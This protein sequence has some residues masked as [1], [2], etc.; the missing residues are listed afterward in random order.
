MNRAAT[1]DKPDQFVLLLLLVHLLAGWAVVSIYDGVRYLL[2]GTIIVIAG[3]VLMVVSNKWW[4]QTSIYHRYFLFFGLLSCEPQWW[5]MDFSFTVLIVHAL[6]I[7]V[8]SAL[9]LQPLLIW[10]IAACYSL[11][12][13]L[14]GRNVIALQ[15]ETSSL[16]VLLFLELFIVAGLHMICYIYRENMLLI[17]KLE[18]EQ[19]FERLGQQQHL[20]TIGQIAASIAHDIRNP[21]TS[22]QGFVQLI[23]KNERRG[24]YQ[25]YYHI[26]RTEIARI[27]KLLREV[28]MLS[29]S[30]TIADSIQA[31][32]LG[33]LLQRLVVLMQPDAIKW[34][35]QIRLHL[36][37]DLVVSGS[38][39]KLQQVFLNVLRNA[40]EAVQENGNIDILLYED[41]NQAVVRIRDT[42]PGIPE[43]KLDNLFTPFYTTKEEGT[44]LGLSICQSI[45]KAHDG[46]ISVRNLPEHGAEFTINIPRVTSFDVKEYA[47]SS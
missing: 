22:I 23:E 39:E 5:H 19:N 38:E 17:R 13:L 14:F 32:Q 35:I 10:A 12:F 15:Q 47:A 30:H 26:I 45:I 28:L 29:K 46:S 42:G 20:A 36:Q 41:E 40:F 34:N 11:G 21:L 44:G 25:E 37:K 18:R 3:A 7:I 33:E 16:M 27:D 2:P 24:S 6:T 31:V 4:R 43:D 8:V 9:Y 1:T